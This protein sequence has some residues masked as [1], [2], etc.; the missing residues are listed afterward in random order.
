MENITKALQQLEKA[1]KSSET[2]KRV[3][4]TITIQ[5]SKPNK[6]KAESK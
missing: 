3:T 6:A 2:V 4:V 5:N 1:V